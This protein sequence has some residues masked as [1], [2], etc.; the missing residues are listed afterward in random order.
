MRTFVFQIIAYIK[1]MIDISINYPLPL[2][3]V[4]FQGK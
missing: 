3:R 4:A 1:L 2:S